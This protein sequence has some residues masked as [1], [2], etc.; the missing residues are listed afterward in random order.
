M[1]MLDL[2][3]LIMVSYETLS[4]RNRVNIALGFL[5]V[6]CSKIGCE[7]DECCEMSKSICKR[8]SEA[9]CIVNTNTISEIFVDE[10]GVAFNSKIL[11]WM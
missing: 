6:D 1:E 11:M 3:V 9:Y 10:C 2:A 7:I 5:K 4:Y 8:S